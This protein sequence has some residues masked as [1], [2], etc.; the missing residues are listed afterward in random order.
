MHFDRERSPAFVSDLLEP[1][2]SKIDWAVIELLKSD[3]RHPADFTIPEDGA[4]RLNP[5]L[6]RR[7]VA[8]TSWQCSARVTQNV[9]V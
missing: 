7:I 2:R 5:E 1:E 8:R 3:A 6:A 4:V 9:T